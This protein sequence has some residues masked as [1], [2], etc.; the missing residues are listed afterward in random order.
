MA[1]GRPPLDLALALIAAAGRPSVAPDDLVGAL[2]DLAAWNRALS[3]EE[4]ARLHALPRGVDSLR[5]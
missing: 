1:L 5:R 3:D 2:D 4:I